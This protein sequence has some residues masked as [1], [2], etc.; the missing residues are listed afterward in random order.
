M[1]EY[2]SIF[3]IKIFLI[4]LIFSSYFEKEYLSLFKLTLY[5]I[6]IYIA[7]NLVNTILLL[8][9]VLIV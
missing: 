7:N 1:N 8:T 9:I 6:I 5:E 3:K 2:L 4:I